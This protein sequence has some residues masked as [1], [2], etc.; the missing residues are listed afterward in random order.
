[1]IYLPD[2]NV[3]IRYLNSGDSVIKV[4]IARLRASEIR[5]CSV[6]KS[7]LLYGAYRSKRRKENV[8]LIKR[9]FERFDSLPFDDSVA[10]YCAQIRTEL[11]ARGKLIGPNDFMI[12]AIAVANDLTVVTHNTREF[13]R[14]DGLK[15]EDWEI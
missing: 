9:L 6:V 12:A 10:E 8:T 7:E 4:R 3:W 5:L 2:T 11:A 13:E 14:I 1:M 15:I